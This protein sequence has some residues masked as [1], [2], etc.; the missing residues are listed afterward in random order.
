MLLD[1]ESSI[2]KSDGSQQPWG[3]GVTDNQRMKEGLSL[4]AED[5]L[6]H[7]LMLLVSVINSE[8]TTVATAAW[9]KQSIENLKDER[10]ESPYWVSTPDLLKYWPQVD[11]F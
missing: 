5:S 10:F 4:E 2:G 3:A 7:P 11:E 9:H 1:K 6:E 8:Q